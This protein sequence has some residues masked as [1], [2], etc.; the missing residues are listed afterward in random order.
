MIN[1]STVK[2]ET[3][4]DRFIR[5]RWKIYKNNPHWV[6]PLIM[7]QKKFLDPKKGPFFKTGKTEYFLAFETNKAMI[8]ALEDLSAQRYKTWRFYERQ[9][10]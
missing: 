1:V 2:S 4:L 6:P 8:N 7:D 5:L 10:P 9:I 3:D